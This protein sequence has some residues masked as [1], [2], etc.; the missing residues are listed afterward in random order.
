MKGEGYVVCDQFFRRIKIKSP[1]YVAITLLKSNLKSSFFQRRL[2]EII[3]CN[4]GEELLSYFPEWS[5]SYYQLKTKYENLIQEIETKYQQHKDIDSDKEFALSIKHLHYSNILFS[6]RRG[7]VF[8]V[9]ESLA[10]TS[11]RKL[12]SLL[13][14]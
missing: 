3:N 10:Q 12:E 8:S 6:L 7:K 1:Q 11:T 9:R 4:E 5:R 2:L 13:D 14:I